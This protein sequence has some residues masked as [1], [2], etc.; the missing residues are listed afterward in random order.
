MAKDQNIE[1]K[2][3]PT[4]TTVRQGPMT[5]L[6][7]EIDRLFDDFSLPDFTFPS[8]RAGAPL[9]AGR[10]WLDQG[11]VYPA[12]DMLERDGS[13]EVQAELPGFDLSGLDIKLSD[14][15]LMIK[16]TKTYEHKEDD[17]DFHL[18]ERQFG[19][20]Q[21]SLRL[22][23]GIN[24]DKI[25]ARFENGVLSVTLPKTAEAK[26]KERKIKVTAA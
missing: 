24:V 8:W 2:K 17:V 12:M 16:G 9:E 7:R 3:E 6:R 15:S 1:I 22:P 26:E 21:R 13:Y 4:P 18:R 14:G 10:L 19:E 25:A 5:A 23:Q 11:G 20:F